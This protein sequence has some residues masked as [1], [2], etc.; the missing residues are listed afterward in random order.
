ML[1][2][3]LA[4]TRLVGAVLDIIIYGSIGAVFGAVLVTV[5]GPSVN[6]VFVVLWYTLYRREEAYSI[7]DSVIG[8]C[9]TQ[10]AARDSAALPL[11][12]HTMVSPP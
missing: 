4:N 9:M 7:P 10:T 3:T 6:V 8:L 12:E 5:F 2:R 1:R 11:H